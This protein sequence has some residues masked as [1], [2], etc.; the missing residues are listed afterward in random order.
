[1][2]LGVQLRNTHSTIK[3]KTDSHAYGSTSSRSKLHDS[4]RMSNTLKT[5]HLQTNMSQ[6]HITPIPVIEK[7][8]PHER[9]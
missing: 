1:M 9:P 2:D 4:K 8:K 3:Y 6:M 5:C 7:N